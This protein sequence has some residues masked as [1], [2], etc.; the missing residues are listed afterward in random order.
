MTEPLPDTWHSRDLP[1]LRAIVRLCDPSPHVT[2]PDS[3][4]ELT[5][6][7]IDDV[8]RAIN[9]LMSDGYFSASIRG[10]GRASLINGVS[11][12]ARRA[13]GAWPSGEVVADRLLSLLEE[14]SEDSEDELVRTRAGKAAKAL[15][16]LGRDVLVSVAGAAAGVAMQG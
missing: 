2:T 8:D 10:D 7:S 4:A 1:V 9:A 12:E 3:V 6:L 14:L 16:G 5:G 11:G 13:T 15:G